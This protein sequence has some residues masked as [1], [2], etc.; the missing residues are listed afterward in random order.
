MNEKPYGV[1][2]QTDDL[3][4]I[5]AINSNAFITDLTDWTKID[6]GCG[7]RYYHAQGNYFAKPIMTIGG[8]YHYKLIEG[9]VV[10][11]T[12]EEIEKAEAENRENT[13]QPTQEERIAELEEALNMILNGVTE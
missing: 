11:C 3:S 10:E 8:V 12:A 7:D 5:T 4:R 9:E 6:E 1:Y 2:V 13:S